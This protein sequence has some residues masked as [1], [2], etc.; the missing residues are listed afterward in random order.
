MSAALKALIV[1]DFGRSQHKGLLAE[2]GRLE[3]T[4]PNAKPKSE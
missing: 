2:T 3:Y 1:F 4:H